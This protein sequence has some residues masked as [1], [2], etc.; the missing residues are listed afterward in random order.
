M[1]GAARNRGNHGMNDATQPDS[2][3]DLPDGMARVV[4]TPTLLQFLDQQCRQAW[5]SSGRF[6]PGCCW[7]LLDV[8]AQH[9]DQLGFSGLER[10]M[11]AVHERV[12]VQLDATDITA[13]FGLDALGAVLDPRAGDRD[14]QLDIK[15][16]TRAIS[17]NLFEIGDHMVAATVSIAIAPAR[18][19]LR[20]V[21]ANLVRVA[22]HA[23]QLSALGGDRGELHTLGEGVRDAGP[24]TLLGQLRKALR[25]GTLKVVYQPLLAT[26]GPE[27]DRAQLLPRLIAAD[28]AL[29]PAARFIPVAAERGVLPAVDQWMIVHALKTLG[30]R[31]DDESQFF[32]NQS[33]A[34][35]D[36]D[37]TIGWLQ[38][39]L[40][41]HAVPARSLV[42]EFNILEIKPRIRKARE[43]LARL[44]KM[45]VA[46]CLTGVDESVPDAIL[47]KHLPADFL[48]MKADFA[49][50]V[51][52][53]ENLAERF[54]AFARLARNA[55]R[56]LIVPMLEDA[57][58]VSR[59]WQMDVDLIQGNFIQQPSEQPAEA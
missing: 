6:P 40:K 35:I 45:G 7:I 39:Q 58:E 44:Q 13:R 59:I 53:D 27:R 17:N 54:Q 29:I 36:D 33:P 30:Q 19:A 21:E 14:Y 50:R 1:V 28:G 43:V 9:R 49:R 20:P 25:D 18:E 57:E 56:S 22:R 3:S 41:E 16:V 12:R 4:R 15:H 48:R 8:M 46:V 38:T 52:D 42:L 10:L 47:L 37:N 24:G 5:Q 31:A 26:Q 2:S 55:G 23:E 34:M 32:L 11:H 51:L